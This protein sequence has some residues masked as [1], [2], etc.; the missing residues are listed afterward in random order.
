MWARK[1]SS[2]PLFILQQWVGGR[3]RKVYGRLSGKGNSKSHG[4]RPV[5]LIITMI[6]W[7][8][9]RRIGVRRAGVG[10]CARPG[11]W[12]HLI[13]CSIEITVFQV[14]SPI[15][16][17]FLLFNPI[18]FYSNPISPIQTQFLLFNPNFSC[19]NLAGTGVRRDGIG[20][21]ARPVVR[22]FCHTAGY[23]WILGGLATT[24]PLPYP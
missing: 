24:L 14:I 4:A 22:R 3:S 20:G 13:M 16:P 8:R 6:K 11:G 21:G 18:F 2:H 19:S 12:F 23:E 5:H 17:R 9:T 15:Q 10:D 7:I 1:P